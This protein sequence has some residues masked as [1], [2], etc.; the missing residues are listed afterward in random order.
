MILD[1]DVSA[2]CLLTR[3]CGLRVVVCGVRR[4]VCGP[5]EVRS[6]GEVSSRFGYREEWSSFS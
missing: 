2:G 5:L 6:S 4:E 3:V 1:D